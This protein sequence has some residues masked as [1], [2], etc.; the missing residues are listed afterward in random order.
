M[1][2]SSFYTTEPSSTCWGAERQEAGHRRD[3][4]A[5]CWRA[6]Y[7][8]P[9]PSVRPI[10]SV[11]STGRQGT[12]QY[13]RVSRFPMRMAPYCTC[14]SYLPANTPRP[15]PLTYGGPSPRY[16]LQPY[17]SSL[18]P[19]QIPSANCFRPIEVDATPEDH[20][21]KTIAH[22]QGLDQIRTLPKLLGEDEYLDLLTD[23]V[24]D[25]VSSLP[26][27]EDVK[28][29]P[30]VTIGDEIVDDRISAGPKLSLYPPDGPIFTYIGYNYS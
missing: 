19:P 25:E 14:R 17:R 26:E 6:P 4:R 21:R 15:H 16:S 28:L 3:V 29:P 1:N 18:P 5:D 13:C 27:V 22:A 23:Q 8:G 7:C 12:L 30:I 9:P 11:G 24:D 2:P 20:R 10:M